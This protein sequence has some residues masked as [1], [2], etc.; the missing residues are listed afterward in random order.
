MNRRFPLATSVSLVQDVFTMCWKAVV[1]G[2]HCR[3]EQWPIN[4]GEFYGHRRHILSA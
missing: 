2:K 4:S 3:R 1:A